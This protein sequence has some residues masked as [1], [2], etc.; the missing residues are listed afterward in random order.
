MNFYDFSKFST[1][2]LPQFLSEGAEIFLPL[3]ILEAHFHFE[4]QDP[5]P[6]IGAWGDDRRNKKIRVFW[7]NGH[8]S[9]QVTDK[10][11]KHR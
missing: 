10:S 2:Y 6:K 3:D 9:N 5:I 1:Q 4:F 11:A 8:I 7:K